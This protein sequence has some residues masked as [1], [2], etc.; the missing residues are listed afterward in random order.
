MITKF[1]GNNIIETYRAFFGAHMGRGN[2]AA[3]TFTKQDA[4]IRIV[5]TFI[6]L[7]IAIFVI[8]VNN[9]DYKNLPTMIIGAIIGY[10]LR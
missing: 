7:G 8:K 6:L 5:V 3:R 9:P 1:I 2:T 4:V 10:W